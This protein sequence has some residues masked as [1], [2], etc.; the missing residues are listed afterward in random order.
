[1]APKPQ[2]PAMS[3]Y[4]EISKLLGV[5][6][7]RLPTLKIG[8]DPEKAAD[9]LKIIKIKI[10]RFKTVAQEIAESEKNPP[11]QSVIALIA[12]AE[13]ELLTDFIAEDFRRKYDAQISCQESRASL[14]KFL[15]SVYRSETT[16]RQKLS[17]LREKLKVLARF[18]N[19]GETF[20]CFLGRQNALKDQIAKLSSVETAEIFVRDNF[21]ERNLTPSDKA[22]LI[23]QGKSE[24]ELSEIAKFLDE[25]QR[26]LPQAAVNAV[27]DELAE[28]RAQN[29]VLAQSHKA[30]TE[31]FEQLAAMY[32]T[33]FGG[34]GTTQVQNVAANQRRPPNRQRRQPYP[35]GQRQP[36]GRPQR[37]QLCGI[38]GHSRD[39]CRRPQNIS[40]Y[41]CG[42][43]G[44]LSYVCPS[45]N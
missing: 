22:F 28:L 11:K 40:C 9:A 35:T 17:S 10:D 12:E 20:T 29:Q 13:L 31:K 27:K 3:A 43:Q 15:K 30:I 32:E 33:Q 34:Q 36:P 23:E 44:H 14:E 41:K 7:P 2:N 1:M 6:H 25:R 16:D 4:I 42:R 21:F 45:K 8:L 38:R 5:S 37:C 19:E 18:S 26:H 39:Q 24:E